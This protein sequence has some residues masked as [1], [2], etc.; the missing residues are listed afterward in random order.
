VLRI[1]HTLDLGNNFRIILAHKRNK[2][3]L[4]LL[5]LLISLCVAGRR[6]CLLITGY[7]R[8]INRLSLV[9][10]LDPV[11]GRG[12]EHL[13]ARVVSLGRGA[14]ALPQ[15]LLLE[16]IDVG[17]LDNAGMRRL[18]VRPTCVVVGLEGLLVEPG[19]HFR[20]LDVLLLLGRQV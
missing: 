18:L 8:K 14:L 2:R 10:I 4:I 17:F 5:S 6:N 16:G 19:S 3:F 1:A 7:S 9:K 15:R 12:K 13:L 11:D 20:S